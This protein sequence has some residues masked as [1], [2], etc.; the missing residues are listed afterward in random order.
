MSFG[1]IAT[2]ANTASWSAAH[3]TAQ[4]EEGRSVPTVIIRVMPQAAALATTPATGPGT[5]FR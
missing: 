1:W 2:A 4:Y 5:R 3:A